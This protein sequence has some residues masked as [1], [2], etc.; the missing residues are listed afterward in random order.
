MRTFKTRTHRIRGVP[1]TV[2]RSCETRSP[3]CADFDRSIQKTGWCSKTGHVTT[4]LL[5]SYQTTTAVQPSLTP[6]QV[7]ADSPSTSCTRPQ[8]V[9]AR[10]LFKT[11]RH[12][13]RNQ[14]QRNTEAQS[15]KQPGTRHFI[16]MGNPARAILTSNI[17]LYYRGE[18]T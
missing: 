5:G 16:C 8:H 10:M 1:S 12:D 17:A 11:C 15:R 14:L 6:S 18:R 2:R 3:Y 9:S 7:H 13:R 4:R